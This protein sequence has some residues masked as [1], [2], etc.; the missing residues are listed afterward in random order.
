M[1]CHVQ[2]LG[3]TIPKFKNGRA[4]WLKGSRFPGNWLDRP[5]GLS[6]EY[7]CVL[8]LGIW[9]FGI[10]RKALVGA[11]HEKAV[12]KQPIPNFL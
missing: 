3:L 4:D 11:N 9:R 5:P 7:F 6:L 2:E 12:W 10:I 1:C 8:E